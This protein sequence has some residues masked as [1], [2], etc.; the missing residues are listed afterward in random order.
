MSRRMTRCLTWGEMR[1]RGAPLMDECG[2]RVGMI[3]FAEY[4]TLCGKTEE[5]PKE[6][7]LITPGCRRPAGV[8]PRCWV[9]NRRAYS[10]TPEEER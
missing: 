1:T 5:D 8:C 6:A 4:V 7:Y 3:D 10:L 9:E 2:R